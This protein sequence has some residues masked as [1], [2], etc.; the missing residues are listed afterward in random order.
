MNNIIIYLSQ[1]FVL[2]LRLPLLVLLPLFF[3]DQLVGVGHKH[4][5][6]VAHENEKQPQHEQA[7]QQAD[8]SD[9]VE[10]VFDFVYAGVQVHAENATY[11][12]HEAEGEGDCGYHYV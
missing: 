10:Q 4:E 2:A 11:H 3:K 9:N 6:L 5:A 8:P 1:H 12:G 7:H